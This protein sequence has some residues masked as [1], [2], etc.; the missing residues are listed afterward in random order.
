MGLATQGLKEQEEMITFL[1]D[2]NQKDE[3]FSL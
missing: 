2:A 1:L 3:P